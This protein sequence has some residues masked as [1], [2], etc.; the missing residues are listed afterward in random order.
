[1]II[2]IKIT[3]SSTKY[4]NNLA[5]TELTL[6]SDTIDELAVVEL[7]KGMAL[8]AIKRAQI[9]RDEQEAKKALPAPPF[10]APDKDV[11]PASF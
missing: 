6:D 1:M 2:E 5:S 3:A 9:K 10:V 7:V 11:E 4:G 8:S